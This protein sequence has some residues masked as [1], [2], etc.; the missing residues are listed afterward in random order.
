MRTSKITAMIAACVIALTS[1]SVVTAEQIDVQEVTQDTVSGSEEVVLSGDCSASPDDHVE[2]RVVKTDE[3]LKYK[4]II[5]GTGKMK[6]FVYNGDSLPNQIEN[7]LDD[8]YISEVEIQDGVLNVSSCA[9]QNSAVEEVSLPE[10]MIEIDINAFYRCRKLK[11]INLPDTITKIDAYSFYQCQKLKNISLPKNLET[12]GTHSFYGSGLETVLISGNIKTVGSSSFMMCDKLKKCILE[13]G[14]TSISDFMF[15]CCSSLTE[16]VFP[17]KWTG[18]IGDDAFT[19]CYRL[20]ELRIPEGVKRLDCS[21]WNYCKSLETI[22]IPST[23]TRLNG[24]TSD[25]PKL[26]DIYFNGSRD[27]WNKIFTPSEEDEKRMEE[28]KITIHYAA[29][30][31]TPTATPIPTATPE[32][33]ATPTPA[34]TPE[35]SRVTGQIYG[36]G[37]SLKGKI[38]ANILLGFTDDKEMKDVD[39]T[40]Q[41]S[42]DGKEI[43]QKLSELNHYTK[44]GSEIYELQIFV[45]AKQIHDKIELTLIDNEEKT[46]SLS[47]GK[48]TL[49][50]YEFSIADITDT[51]L[52]HPNMYGERTLDLIEAIQN[53][54]GYAQLMTG[55]KTDT[56]RITDK[57]KYIKAQDLKSYATVTEKNS[58]IA[59]F[60]GVGLTLQT[61][62]SM[63]VYFKLTD[64]VD[65]YT[66]TV[67]KETVTPE[68]LGN[69]Q[70]CVDLTSIPAG[71]LRTASEI[72]IRKGDE[73][74]TIKASALSWAESVLSNSK[75]QKQATINMAKMLYRYSQKADE[76]FG[77]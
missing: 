72:V 23:T 65:S 5:S 73:T 17:E 19:N 18:K 2:W 37:L 39:P 71:K 15:S 22:H 46:I 26:T 40:V 55:Y 51:Y 49:T 38:G 25:T 14:N 3:E 50:S 47:H 67:D 31:A 57:L 27:R 9:F 12:L 52:A 36:T 44:N 45:P 24:L 48:K 32:P 77:R 10:C 16:V 1:P 76:Y 13:D 68:S 20:K 56:V 70:Y 34:V 41:I 43:E 42:V 63:Q 60:T 8:G 66:F 62:T 7:E 21:S 53:F 54:C 69:N 74:F 35:L 30:E 29:A 61:D 75:T 28:G 11:K 64:A 58:R 59:K 6:D 4:L 33:T